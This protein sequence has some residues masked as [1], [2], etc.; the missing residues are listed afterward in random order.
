MTIYNISIFYFSGYDKITSNDHGFQIKWS[1]TCTVP[2]N[3]TITYRK[4]L[5]SRYRFTSIV[6]KTIAHGTQTFN[7]GDSTSTTLNFCDPVIGTINICGTEH[8]LNF[9]RDCDGKDLSRLISSVT[10]KYSV[11][12]RWLDFH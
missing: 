6:N 11:N 7:S 4:V 10:I 1:N 5:S 12:V 9:V 8:N 2:T 3:T